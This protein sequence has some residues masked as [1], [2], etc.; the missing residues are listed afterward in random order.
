MIGSSPTLP[1]PVREG[2]LLLQVDAPLDLPR[3]TNGSTGFPRYVLA[4]HDLAFEKLT[5]A[6]PD[7]TSRFS[8]YHQDPDRILHVAP[9]FMGQILCQKKTYGHG[10]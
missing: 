8:N 9:Q 2:H 4:K 6:V 5:T 7:R 10:W 1:H 3:M